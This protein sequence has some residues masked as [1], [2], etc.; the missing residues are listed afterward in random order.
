MQRQYTWYS[1]NTDLH[2]PET[3]HNILSYGTLTDIID[4]EKK[5]GKEKI[6]EIF[7]KNPKKV[8][9]NAAFH[10]ISKFIFHISHSLD[11]HEYI[12]S[13]PRNIR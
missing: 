7:T 8:Y 9:T 1:T 11:E 12:K 3:I 6:R 10:F 2:S 13:S 5:L 4:L